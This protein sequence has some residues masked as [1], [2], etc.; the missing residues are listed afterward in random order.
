MALQTKDFSVTRASAGGGIT[1]TFTIRV[2][3][4]STNKAN[5]T[6]NLT[7][8][9]IL[10][11]SYSGTA[12]YS[13]YT[14]VSCSLNGTQVFSDYQKRS[15]SGTSETVYY[16]WTGNVQHAPDGSLNLKVDGKFWQSSY[17]SY[18]PPAMSVSGTWALTPIPRASII[19]ATDA[20]I[21]S[22]TNIVIQAP[23]E[24]FTHSIAYSFGELTGYITPTGTA[25]SEVQFTQTTLN[26]TVP[27]AF[28]NE[29]PGK[30]WAKCTLT[31]RT[32]SGGVLLGEPQSTTFL[33]TAA[34]A[35]CAPTIFAQVQDINEKTIALTGDSGVLIRYHSTAQ[36]TVE[37]Q[38]YCGAS[39]TSNR[40]NGSL[41]VNN[42]KR[43]EDVERGDFQFVARDTRDWFGY[44]DVQ[45]PL[46]PYTRLTNNPVVR[47]LADGDPRILVTLSGSVW[48]GNFGLAENT[49][50]V[51]CQIN[52]RNPVTAPV[53]IDEN[54][55]YT[56]QVE[57]DADYTQNS[58]L[59]VVAQDCLDR[60]SV[61]LTVQK[62][63]PVF[64]WGEND[65]F[66]HVPVHCDA[67]VS[68]LYIR[69]VRVWGQSSLRFQSRFTQWGAAGNR[70][71]VLIFGSQ[72]GTPVLGILLISSDGMAWWSG[73][74]GVTPVVLEQGAVELS[75]THT[76][77][78]YIT[79][80]ST[81]PI[82][83]L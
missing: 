79:L 57:M 17:E 52:S 7:V 47:R 15:L 1:Y 30:K 37:S 46:I 25:D 21:G 28:Y 65:F 4:N 82:T 40:V 44:H 32:Y 36:C 51:T 23:G 78:D 75:M 69:P 72:N 54:G 61:K 66:F 74:E 81:E 41:I 60:V 45:L 8:K 27:E 14:G 50:T 76:A 2:T 16:T 20:N 48:L 10:K 77:Y 26:W 22:V 11:Q 67:A 64:H 12:F 56:A 18:S 5:N 35:N 68:G 38:A 71:S 39:I 9:A 19:T 6:S 59:T 29:I 53:T 24:G 31:C 43:I 13:W 83:V 73:T 33:A 63:T 62:G 42:I 34:E 80:L 58:T 55:H 70:Q 49:L 3:E